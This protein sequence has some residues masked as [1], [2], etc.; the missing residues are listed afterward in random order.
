MNIINGIALGLGIAFS[1]IALLILMHRLLRQ[2]M[3]NRW[4]PQP[5]YAEEDKDA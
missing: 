1:I 2:N 4:E 5:L 3:S